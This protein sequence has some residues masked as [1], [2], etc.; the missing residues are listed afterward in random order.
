[1]FGSRSGHWGLVRG[2]LEGAG[3]VLV[4]LWFAPVASRS[5]VHG[6]QYIGWQVPLICSDWGG[7]THVREG[8]MVRAR[9]IVVVSGSSSGGSPEVARGNEGVLVGPG[10]PFQDLYASGASKDRVPA[11]R[12]CAL[13]SGVTSSTTAVEQILE[14][15]RLVTHIEAVTWKTVKIA[16]KME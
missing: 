4:E 11:V 8:W 15:R 14:G 12:N 6:S 2:L 10:Y 5:R 13:S 9:R 1:M 16:Q 7:E 3:W